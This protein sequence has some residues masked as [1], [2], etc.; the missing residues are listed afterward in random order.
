[1]V[2]AVAGT[3]AV[4]WAGVSAL[5][6][7]IQQAASLYAQSVL[8]M[9]DL[10]K[11]R[12][13]EGDARV[14]VQEIASGATVDPAEVTT[15]DKAIDDGFDDYV[16]HEGSGL[17]ASRATL[18]TQTRAALDAWRKIRDTQ[19]IPAAQQGDVAGAQ[20]VVAGA[21][22]QADEAFAGPLDTLSDEAMA[23]AAVKA[24][25]AKRASD[26]D[27]LTMI[28]VAILA[29]VLAAIA[30]LVIARLVSAP[31]RRV[32]AVLAG[33][34]DG[35]LTGEPNVDSRDEIGQMA[36]ALKRAA[37][38]LRHTITTMA[39]SASALAAATTELSSTNAQISGQ[40]Q[41]SAAQ[42]AIVASAA[43]TVSSNVQTL[44]AGAD[45]MQAAIGEIASNAGL[46]AR[47][48]SDAVTTVANTTATIAQLGESSIGISEVLRVI[49]SIAEQTNLLALNATIEAARAGEAGKGFA[50]VAGEVKE[51]AQQ[52]AAATEDIAKRVT[53]IQ[54]SS[55]EATAAVDD[56]REI[57]S[58]INDYQATIAAAVEEQ[59]ATTAEMQRNVNEAAHGSTEIAVNIG[60]VAAST[61]ATRD[62][63]DAGQATIAQLAQMSTDLQDLVGRFRY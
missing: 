38:S 37:A 9:A 41:E 59:T 20:A 35:D 13:G 8:P 22:A 63:V 51:L 61:D 25:D 54:T 26:R 60:A 6:S 1:V 30:G 23:A 3:G 42:T 17:S 50:V 43:D 16:A 4:L 14:L 39:A 19:I 2:L 57:I 33:L 11:I 24:A 58:K 55:G 12:D 53:A 21:L 7:T 10:S 34:A 31:L 18:V 44:A 52:T 48:A 27:K 49:T 28:V 29:A 45:E 46:A 40:A 62:G 32:Q 5:D 47:V 56:I 36:G 15:A